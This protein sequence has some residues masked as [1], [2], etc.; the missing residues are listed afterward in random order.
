MFQGM[1]RLGQSREGAS[2][3]RPVEARDKFLLKGYLCFEN[4]QTL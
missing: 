4:G 1:D 2:T 3:G